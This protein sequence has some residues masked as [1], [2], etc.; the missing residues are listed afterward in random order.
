MPSRISSKISKSKRRS[1]N[2]TIP[3]NPAA[4]SRNRIKQIPA[5]KAVTTAGQPQQGSGNKSGKDGQQPRRRSARRQGKQ[6]PGNSGDKKTRVEIRQA[7]NPRVT[8]KPGSGQSNPTRISPDRA[9]HRTPAVK[10]SRIR[11]RRTAIPAASPTPAHSRKATRTPANQPSGNQAS[12]QPNNGG[13]EQRSRN[14]RPARRKAR[15]PVASRSPIPSTPAA[16]RDSRT[17]RP[18]A[19]RSPKAR[20]PAASRARTSSASGGNPPNAEKK[21]PGARAVAMKSNRPKAARRPS[22]KKPAGSS[23]SGSQNLPGGQEA[24]RKAQERDRQFPGRRPGFETQAGRKAGRRR[25]IR[26]RPAAQAGPRRKRRLQRRRQEA[27][28]GKPSDNK[29]GT[30]DNEPGQKDPG[31]TGDPTPRQQR[32]PRFPGRQAIAASRS[33]AM[34]TKAMNSDKSQ[35]PGNSPHDSNSE[36]RNPRRSQRRWWGR[37]AVKPTRR[38]ARGR[39]HAIG[40]QQ[41]RRRLQ[42]TR[43]RRHR[44]EGRRSGSFHRSDRFG[45]QGTRQGQ[46]RETANRPTRKRPTTTRKIR[47]TIPRRTRPKARTS[48]AAAKRAPSPPNRPA[49]KAPG[50]PAGGSPSDGLQQPH[51]RSPASPRADP[52]RPI[53]SSPRNRS[54]W[55]WNISKIKKTKRSRSC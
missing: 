4:I 12:S 21:Q 36:Q 14:L 13:Q 1:S 45:P 7:S 53:S 41:W 18:A 40:G 24:G 29:G 43:R 15:T 23:G 32:C 54:I 34:P 42:R 27:Q 48:P 28:G 19:A 22:E 17:N 26:R 9:I 35:S 20:N 31:K 46:R 55:P 33:P 5:S 25:T 8:S 2:R 3:S 30:A 39:R 52:T 10:A 6:S 37:V 11:R 16:R 44:Q 50:P 38:P 51:R 49:S 47:K